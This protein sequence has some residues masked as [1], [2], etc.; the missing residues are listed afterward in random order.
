MMKCMSMSVG[1]NVEISNGSD[2]MRI[3]IMHSRMQKIE[4]SQEILIFQYSQALT[5][6]FDNKI[7]L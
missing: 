7:F 3:A 6:C 2:H 5:I 4:M 1:N